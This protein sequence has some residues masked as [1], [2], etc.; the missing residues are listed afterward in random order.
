MDFLLLAKHTFC[1]ETPTFRL[2]G[3][4]ELF[5]LDKFICACIATVCQ[6]GIPNLSVCTHECICVCYIYKICDRLYENP[7]RLRTLNTSQKQL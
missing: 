3:W 2:N 4:L 7:P 5:L 1:G 6:L